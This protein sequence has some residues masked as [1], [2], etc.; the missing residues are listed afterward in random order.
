MKYGFKYDKIRGM[1]DITKKHTTSASKIFKK[2]KGK[3]ELA[4][5]A[6]NSPLIDLAIEQLARIIVDSIDE[7]YRV[8][9]ELKTQDLDK[10]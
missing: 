2:S 1:S 7:K 9:N 4:F 3:K 6:Q 5:T 8:K 10:K